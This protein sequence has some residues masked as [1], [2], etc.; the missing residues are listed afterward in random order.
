MYLIEFKAFHLNCPQSI[1][2][3]TVQGGCQNT[4]V[5]CATENNNILYIIQKLIYYIMKNM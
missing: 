3:N 2:I 5:C 1:Y 4:P